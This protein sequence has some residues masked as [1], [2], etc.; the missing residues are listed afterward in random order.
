MFSM[1]SAELAATCSA[2]GFY[3]HEKNKYFADSNTLEAVKD[4]IRY[5]RRDDTSH[6][7]RRELGESKVL[8][9]DLLPLLKNYWEEAD[10]FDVLL[11]LI[12]NLTTPALIL[13]EEELPTDKTARNHY[14]QIEE[15]L[16]LY[17]EAFVDND[18][19]AVLSTKL[20]TILEIV[21]S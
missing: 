9:T 11:R 5:L 4:L 15:H 18:V 2:L 6:A 12:V 1:I 7:I 8:K 16:Q 10:L 3:D 14:L 21:S 13:Y 17:K 19:W 20:S